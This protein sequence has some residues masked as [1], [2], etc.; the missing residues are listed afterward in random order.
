MSGF[1]CDASLLRCVLSVGVRVSSL[2]PA[3]TPTRAC[4]VTLLLGLQSLG[5]HSGE[6]L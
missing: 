5:T 4:L 6:L 3:L 1:T 2:T